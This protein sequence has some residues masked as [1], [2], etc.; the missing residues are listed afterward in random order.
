MFLIIKYSDILVFFSV[1]S[2]CYSQFLIITAQLLVLPILGTD[3]HYPNPY[4]LLRNCHRTS[5]NYFK[6]Y[7]KEYKK[8]KKRFFH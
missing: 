1:G 8:K 7:Q 2:Y 4:T 3:V 5:A 6:F